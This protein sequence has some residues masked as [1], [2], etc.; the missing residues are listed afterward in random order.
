MMWNHMALRL[1]ATLPLVGCASAFPSAAMPAALAPM[2]VADARTWAA[3]TRPPGHLTL[4]FHWHLIA[5]GGSGGRGTVLIAPPDSLRLDFRGPVGFGSGAAGVIGDSAIWAE[6]EDQ[7]QKF[8]PS[9]PLLWAMVGIARPPA[10]TWTIEGRRDAST[11]AWR[12]TRGADRVDYLFR[13]G[14]STIL[15]AYVR[16]DGRPLGHVVTVFDVDG[17][18]ARSRLDV[19]TTQAR[20]EITFDKETRQI[21]FNRDSWLAPHN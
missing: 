14:T 12:Y 15:E 7:V 10:G 18:L 2:P 13:R 16:Q 21:P 6:P 11:T 4:R 3:S 19:L 5:E 9:Y 17:R 20:L 8:V 1:A